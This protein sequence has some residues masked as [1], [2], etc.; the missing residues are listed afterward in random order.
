MAYSRLK[1]IVFGC[2]LPAAK[3]L[4]ALPNLREKGPSVFKIYRLLFPIVL[5]TLLTIQRSLAA[6]LSAMDVLHRTATIYRALHSY[7]FAVT[8]DFV[9]GQKVSE[10]HLLERGLGPNKYRIE[11]T[12]IG[13]ITIGDGK[14]EWITSKG[15]SEYAKSAITPETA[16]PISEFENIDQN[17]T[18]ATIAREEM[19]MVEGKPVPVYVIM[20]KR[21]RW[22]VGT[23]PHAT[24]V[25]Y[26]VD[27]QSFMVDKAITYAEGLTRIALYSITKW[28]QD[29][30]PTLFAFDPEHLSVSAM[31][32]AS[33][34]STTIV[35]REAPD[36]TLQNT[37]GKAVHLVDLRGKVVLVDFWATWCQPCRALMPHLQKMH[38]ELSSKGLVI[39]G[40]DIGEEADDV[41]E[42][43]RN[44]SYTFPVLLG[45]EP[46]VSSKYYVEG[47]PTTFVIDRNGRIIFRAFAEDSSAELRKVVETALR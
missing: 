4:N 1:N 16:T 6:D 34:A 21:S 28:N 23:P 20:V 32:L 39:L 43:M 27:E 5:I 13:K 40:L 38:E 12:G 45:A 24:F 8:I 31:K 35:G 36:F 19:F 3:M 33:P 42:F 44:E 22:P 37:S 30:D 29:V 41:S 46:D 10:Q 7:E 26:R 47:Y 2:L 25:S 14:V 11:E 18:E 17:V 15:S 9:Q